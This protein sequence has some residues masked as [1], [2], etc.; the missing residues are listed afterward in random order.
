MAKESKPEHPSPYLNDLFDSIDHQYD[1]G[2]WLDGNLL[3]Y[4]LNI[5]I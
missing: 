3:L 1:P 5:A 2:Y 4:G